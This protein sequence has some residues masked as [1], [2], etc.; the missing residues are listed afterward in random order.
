LGTYLVL[1][2]PSLMLQNVI[3]YVGKERKRKRE[4]EKESRK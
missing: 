4:R 3:V 2:T 1:G